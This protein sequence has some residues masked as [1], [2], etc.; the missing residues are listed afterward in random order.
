MEINTDTLTRTHGRLTLRLPHLGG[1]LH[2][3]QYFQQLLEQAPLI[4]FNY[5][6]VW[7]GFIM[8]HVLYASFV[9]P[10]TYDHHLVLVPP[11]FH[12]TNELSNAVVNGHVSYRISSWFDGIGLSFDCG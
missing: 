7:N 8:F 11:S 4:S 2:C 9:L 6:H 5:G 10:Q 1:G 3:S 12:M